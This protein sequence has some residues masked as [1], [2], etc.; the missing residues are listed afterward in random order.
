[1]TRALF[2]R[3]HKSHAEAHVFTAVLC[4]CDQHVGPKYDVLCF[5]MKSHFRVLSERRLPVES[6][7]YFVRVVS[8]HVCNWILLLVRVIYT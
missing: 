5:D 6:Q 3:S 4:A 7:E 8:A 1:M 2:L